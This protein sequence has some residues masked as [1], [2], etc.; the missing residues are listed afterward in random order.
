MINLLRQD[1]IKILLENL[2]K[3]NKKFKFINGNTLTL[4]VTSMKRISVYDQNNLGLGFPNSSDKSVWEGYSLTLSDSVNMSNSFRLELSNYQKNFYIYDIIEI[5]VINYDVDEELIYISV[6][7]NLAKQNFILGCPVLSLINSE[8]SENNYLYTC[9]QNENKKNNLIVK[10]K[11]FDCNKIKNRLKRLL[12]ISEQK[13]IEKI[14]KE[15]IKKEKSENFENLGKFQNLHNF[16]KLTDS[17]NFIEKK[18][19]QQIPEFINPFNIKIDKMSL[20]DEK[21]RNN[22]KFFIDEFIKEFEKNVKLIEESKECIEKQNSETTE[23]IDASKDEIDCNKKMNFRTKSEYIPESS[24]SSTATEN[25]NIIP[26]YKI[27]EFYETKKFVIDLCA[28]IIEIQQ[29]ET[30]MR[31]FIR[32][33]D[34]EKDFAELIL[35]KYIFDSYRSLLFIG[36]KILIKNIFINY[37]KGDC[38]FYLTTNKN[39]TMTMNPIM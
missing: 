39:F 15:H 13:P 31:Y 33:S 20:F 1:S 29:C 25:K 3:K 34:S 38:K 12:T 26:L 30:K 19:K 14:E 37:S 6:I 23:K 16:Q 28:R 11:N 2:S 7:N 8:N 35:N 10:T 36:S 27:K 5:C 9:D 32:V 21:R 24:V 18:N 17:S 4:Q 22:D